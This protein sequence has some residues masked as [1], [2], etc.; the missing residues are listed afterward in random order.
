MLHS[1]LQIYYYSEIT[2]VTVGVE[3]VCQSIDKMAF[4]IIKVMKSIKVTMFLF[5]TVKACIFIQLQSLSQDL[6]LKMKSLYKA[7]KMECHG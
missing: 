3:T 4:L 7:K 5:T 6:S 2:F 1:F